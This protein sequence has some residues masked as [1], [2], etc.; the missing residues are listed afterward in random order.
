MFKI[1]DRVH[2]NFCANL[3]IKSSFKIKDNTWACQTDTES[4]LIKV[5]SDVLTVG[6][7]EREYKVG[8]CMRIVGITTKLKQK[9]T[10]SDIVLFFN[11]KVDPDYCDH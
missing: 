9:I 3:K 10:F 2:F 6:S 7:H 11:W 5:V 8:D 1:V 4:V